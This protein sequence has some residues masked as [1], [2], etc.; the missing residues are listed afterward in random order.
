M[1]YGIVTYTRLP[2]TLK[3]AIDRIAKEQDKTVAAVLRQAV[4]EFIAARA[5]TPTSKKRVTVK[6]ATA[7]AT[8]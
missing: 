7:R 5:T 6:Q 8:N 1:E 3:E 4:Q 2:P